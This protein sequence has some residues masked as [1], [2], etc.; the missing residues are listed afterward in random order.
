[1]LSILEKHG[2][3][4]KYDL[5]MGSE[6]IYEP[7]TAPEFTRVLLGSIGAY[8][9]GLVAAK[10]IYFGVGGSVGDFVNGV[11]GHGGEEGE[12]RWRVRTIEEVSREMGGVGGVIL[13]VTH[14]GS[15][16]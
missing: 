1:M 13:E 7:R 2:E 4:G 6:T 3:G 14:I 15:E 11:E 5:V 9:K 10:R 8:G 12:R 16:L